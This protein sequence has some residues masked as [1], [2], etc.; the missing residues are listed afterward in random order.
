M[1]GVIIY[2]FAILGLIVTSVI[3]ILT[4][5]IPLWIDTYKL[6]ISCA[7]SGGFGG[8]LYCL[9]GVYLNAAVKKNWDKDWHVWYYLRP[10]VSIIAGL[11]S[12]I[13]LKAGLLVLE[14]KVEMDS[15]FFGFWALAFIAG[16]NVDKFINKIED[17]AKATW[18][19]EKSRTSKETDK[20]A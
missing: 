13:F 9:R 10:F 2:L 19:I 11:A 4:G 20:N 12:Y 8:I 1:I 15:S 7:I 16:L 17:L 14:S 6:P 18:G 3:L 5:N